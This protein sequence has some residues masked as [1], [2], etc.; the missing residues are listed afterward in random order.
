MNRNIPPY[1]P[2]GKGRGGVIAPDV[3]QGGE[4]ASVAAQPDGGA[5]FVAARVAC[6]AMPDAAI[7]DEFGC[8]GC[9]RHLSAL[10]ANGPGESPYGTQLGA[11]RSLQGHDADLLK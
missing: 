11:R 1:E 10:G 8:F 4:G 2:L 7:V 9:Q 6:P 5:E 3:T